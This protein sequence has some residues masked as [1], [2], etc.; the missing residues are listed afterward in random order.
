LCQARS[1]WRQRGPSVR[2]ARTMAHETIAD[3]LVALAEYYEATAKE[4]S[5]ADTVIASAL[6]V[7][8]AKGR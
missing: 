4:G 1:I 2:V 6:Q 5:H 8:A 3:R 7:G